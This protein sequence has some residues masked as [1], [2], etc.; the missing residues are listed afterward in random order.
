MAQDWNIKSRGHV[1]SVCGQPLVDRAPAVSALGVPLEGVEISSLPAALDLIDPEGLRSP[2]FYVS[3]KLSPRLSAIRRERKTIDERIRLEGLTEELSVARTRLAANEEDA[4]AEARTALC[5][6]L[7]PY[8]DRMLRYAESVGRLDFTLGKARLA[9]KYGAVIPQVGSEHFRL[10]EMTNPRLAEALAGNGR[11][12]VPVSLE[13]VRGSVVVTGAN[14][15]GKS[16]ALKTLALNVRLAMSGFAVFASSAELPF[17]DDLCLLSEDREDAMSGLSSFGGEMRAFDKILRE[18]EGEECCLV[19]LDEFARGTNP[20]E[21]AAL[22]RAA[23]RLF[24]ERQNTFAVIATHFDGVARLARLHYQV[25]GLRGADPSAIRAR[26]SN[27]VSTLAEFMDYGLYPVDPEQAP[28]RDAIT[29][30]HALGVKKE[31]TDLID[32]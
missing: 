32:I 8:A 26:I 30:I 6:R 24:N 5:E 19:L 14:M 17:I 18:T 29:I 31:F 4:N 25:A 15:G 12:F 20:Q 16:V 11:S 27:G 28:P 13:L 21:G 10:S 22:V 3:D 1:C 2:S 7:R 23:A 9:E